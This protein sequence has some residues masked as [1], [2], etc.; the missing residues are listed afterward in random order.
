MIKAAE[1]ECTLSLLSCCSTKREIQ[2]DKVM[3]GVSRDTNT[4]SVFRYGWHLKMT[5][6]LF[7]KRNELS[8]I[9]DGLERSQRGMMTGRRPLGDISAFQSASAYQE[10]WGML[11]WLQFTVYLSEIAGLI[12]Q[13]ETGPERER[14]W[15]YSSRGLTVKGRLLNSNSR[16]HETNPHGSIWRIF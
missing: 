14:H 13:V 6:F 7:T 1:L 3:Q 10:I 4:M 16:H 8:C 5:G 12:K 9:S 15:R 2:S 11:V